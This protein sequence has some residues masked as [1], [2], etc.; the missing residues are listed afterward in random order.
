MSTTIRNIVALDVGEKRVGVAMTNSLARLPQPFTTLIRDDSFWQNLD[1][2]VAE[3]SISEF[4]VGLPRNL[5]G[6]DTSQTASTRLFVRDLEKRFGIQVQ[7][8]DEALTSV[9]AEK[10]LRARGRAYAKGDIDALAATY[11]LEDYLDGKEA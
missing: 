9:K 11:I 6:N 4:V 8:Q 1:K 3:E 5:E 10:E 7:L 2:L